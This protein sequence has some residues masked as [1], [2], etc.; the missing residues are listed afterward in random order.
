MECRHQ[1]QNYQKHPKINQSSK[2]VIDLKTLDLHQNTSVQLLAFKHSKQK[3]LEEIHL[4][5]VAKSV[6]KVGKLQ[7]TK[8]VE[9]ESDVNGRDASHNVTD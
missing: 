8:R 9:R 2:L 5:F 1:F 4:F 7:D 3:H 6:N